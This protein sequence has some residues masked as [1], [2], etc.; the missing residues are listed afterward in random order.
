MCEVGTM[1]QEE[2]RKIVRRKE[3]GLR[4][5]EYPAVYYN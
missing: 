5:G 1:A 2:L 4:V 3:R